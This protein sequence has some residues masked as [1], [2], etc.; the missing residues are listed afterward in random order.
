VL[1]ASR[2]FNNPTILSASTSVPTPIGLSVNLRVDVGA[3]A[4]IALSATLQP[5]QLRARLIGTATGVATGRA[6]ASVGV[7]CASAGVEFDLR[8]LDTRLTASFDAGYL[9][10]LSGTLGYRVEAARMLINLFAE[11]CGLRAT[12]NVFDRTYGIVS[13]TRTLL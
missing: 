4:S 6:S 5:Q 3:N 9:S 1:A 11:L 7:L 13:G 10:G 12:V 2:V 8:L